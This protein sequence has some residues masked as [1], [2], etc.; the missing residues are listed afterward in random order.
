MATILIECVEVNSVFAKY[1]GN[2]PRQ[3]GN[4]NLAGG[5]QERA[6]KLVHYDY[7]K[8]M[9]VIQLE[10]AL[11]TEK[12]LQRRCSEAVYWKVILNHAKFLDPTSLPPAKGP[13]D[14][15]SMAE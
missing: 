7:K 11:S 3:D 2:L 12:A 5:I 10:N 6:D 1:H 13:T 8:T 15:F 9:G 14:G 4:I